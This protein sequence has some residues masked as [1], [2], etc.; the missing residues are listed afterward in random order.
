MYHPAYTA[1]QVEKKIDFLKKM[2]KDGTTDDFRGTVSHI[3]GEMSELMAEHQKNMSEY[4]NR[5]KSE[6]EYYYDD[7]IIE[8]YE[9]MDL[10]NLKHKLSYSG[11]IITSKNLRELINAHRD[12]M[13]NSDEELHAK[14]TIVD[15]DIA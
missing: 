13:N 7:L 14:I 9:D 15:T 6:Q 3:V 12:L 1:H 8:F 2:I 4:L 5:E 11:G 10:K